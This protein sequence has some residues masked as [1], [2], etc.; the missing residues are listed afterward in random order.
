MTSH[1]DAFFVVAALSCPGRLALIPTRGV[2]TGVMWGSDAFI[3]QV[4]GPATVC[5]HVCRHSNY[6]Q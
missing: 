2:S 5:C 6:C 4:V 3:L 1:Y